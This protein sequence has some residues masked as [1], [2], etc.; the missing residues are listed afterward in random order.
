MDYIVS[1]LTP[2]GEIR[3]SN[4]EIEGRL[5]WSGHR[6]AIP[7]GLLSH[8]LNYNYE[9]FKNTYYFLDYKKWKD[10][11]NFD[12]LKPGMNQCW[13]TNSDSRKALLKSYDTLLEVVN[14]VL[15][16]TKKIFVIEK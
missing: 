15:G 9:K 13:F 6:L 2:K 1:N 14:E 12:T 16:D 11:Y 7:D 8:I 5:L 4:K 10:V 3:V